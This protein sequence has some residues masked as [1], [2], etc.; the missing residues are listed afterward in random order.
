MG[1]V[2]HLRRETL[3]HNLQRSQEIIKQYR[4]ARNKFNL[5]L[6]KLEELMQDVEFRMVSGLYE[7][8]ADA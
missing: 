7:T 1:K 3:Q 2:R 6:M 5:K 8:Q 4:E